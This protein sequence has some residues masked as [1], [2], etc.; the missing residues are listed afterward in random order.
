MYAHEFLETFA[1]G[2]GAIGWFSVE[3]FAS[4]PS[5]QTFRAQLQTSLMRGRV[6]IPFPL[7]FILNNYIPKLA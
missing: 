7:E 1:K 6:R 2:W 5:L 3:R 4:T